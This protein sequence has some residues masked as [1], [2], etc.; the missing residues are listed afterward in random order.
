MTQNNA[1]VA[2][3]SEAVEAGKIAIVGLAGRFPGAQT[4]DQFW[5]NL[6]AGVE[7]RT[8]FPDATLAK[9]LPPALLQDPAYVKA[10][11]V[12]DHAEEFDA[13]FFDFTR[14]QA[15]ITD[16]Q[17][18]LFLECVWE[19]LETAGIPVDNL[20]AQAAQL[21]G[22]YAGASQSTYT[23]NEP[24]HWQGSLVESL[25]LLIGNDK[26]YL[27]TQTAYRL[28]LQGPCM[29]IQSA[30]STGL[31]A[32]HVGCQSLLNYECDVAVAGAV[33]VRLPQERGY[34]F[35]DG[36]ILAVD[37]HCR[38]FDAAAT[39]TVFGN[40]AGVVVLKRLSDA[41]T[42]GDTI[43]AVIRGSAVNNDGARKF[44]F[45]TSSPMGQLAVI[46]EAWNMAG[47]T[48]DMITYVETHGTGT[49]VGDPIEVDTLASLFAAAV[50][51]P[52]RTTKTTEKFCAIG[53]VKT[54]V[55]HLESAAGIT[56][57]IKTVLAL[58]HRQIPPSLHYTT[59]NPKIDFSALPLYVNT[60][61][62]DW[63]TDRLPRRAGVSSFGIGGTNA[64]LV[65]EEAPP[66]TADTDF[67]RPAQLLTLS[68]KNEPA[69]RD[70][71]ARYAAFLASAEATDLADICYTSHVGRTHFA[72]RL[73][74][75]GESPQQIREKLLAHLQGEATNG[76]SQGV[77][78]PNHAA[79]TQ[80]ANRIAF[81]FTGQGSQY[82]GMGREL[83][84]SEPVF[85]TVIDR[86][87]VVFQS[88][89]GRSLLELLYPTSTPSHNDLLESHPCG[90]ATNFALQCALADLWQSWG[91]QPAA[92]L[93]HSLGD[94]AA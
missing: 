35:E 65:L 91:V 32:V 2:D 59:P 45:T 49:Q 20:G 11:F 38:A 67:E 15:Q 63:N 33:T 75:V 27:A 48:A 61:L 18:R 50:R 39:G 79:S 69:L 70:L 62:A 19:A 90:Q 81:L 46:S 58:H 36:G 8:T 22:V 92:V 88:V 4:I 52:H 87:H 12:L 84:A 51:E 55:G 31:V 76:V 40:G 21:I 73:S 34:L 7:A 26:D 72:H 25:P 3:T 80:D 56:G 30:C 24:T 53:S 44:N 85:R 78:A 66:V 94:F 82:V 1:P 89:L 16:P 29:T 57:L 74:V 86:C 23:T 54:N 41:L 83:Y 64:H 6:C 10:G 14:R 42:D 13:D 47:V 68:A 17:Q 93:G 43:W 77:L 71:T 28:N 5:A 60:T 9:Y 37:G